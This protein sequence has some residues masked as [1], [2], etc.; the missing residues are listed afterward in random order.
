MKNGRLMKFLAVMMLVP[1][2]IEKAK[3]QQGAPFGEEDY[4]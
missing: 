2:M 4:D 1:V 3:Q